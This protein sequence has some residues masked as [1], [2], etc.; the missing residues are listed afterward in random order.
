MRAIGV[1]S[2][3]LAPARQR[4]TQHAGS[5]QIRRANVFRRA[6]VCVHHTTYVLPRRRLIRARSRT[7]TWTSIPVLACLTRPAAPGIANWSSI[8]TVQTNDLEGGKQFPMAVTEQRTKSAMGHERTSGSSE[9]RMSALPPIADIGWL[10]GN[11]RFVP[12]HVIWHPG[13][14]IGGCL[15]VPG[16][17]AVHSIR[18]GRQSASLAERRR[19]SVEEG[20][21]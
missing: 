15:N 20:A 12:N 19:L 1:G 6:P 9:L 3:A 5:I 2:H 11:V 10:G 8:V 18:S 21:R 4:P 14:S 7:T 17:G 13:N 16:G